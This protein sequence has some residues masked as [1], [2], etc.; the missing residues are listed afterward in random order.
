M[1]AKKHSTG[2]LRMR[3]NSYGTKKVIGF[4]GRYLEEDRPHTRVAYFDP[5]SSRKG[6]PNMPEGYQHREYMGRKIRRRS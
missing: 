5:V 6:L 3:E 2:S 1:P 4:T